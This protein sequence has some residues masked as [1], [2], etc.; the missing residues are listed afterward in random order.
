MLV[1]ANLLIYAIDRDS[2][3]HRRAAAWLRASLRG[4]R[5]IGIPW[6]TLL[7]FFRIVT[8]PR[9]YERPLPQDAAWQLIELWLSCDRVWLPQPTAQHSE[10][11]GQL[12]GQV[13]VRG[14]MI[15][16]AHLAALAYEHGLRIA[17]ADADFKRFSDVQSFN[18][19]AL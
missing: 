5:R 10:V 4:P 18:P 13:F 6:A 14:G 2:P 9:I 7:A 15:H 17:T 1:D 8:S 19:L 16:D 11:M 12:L 3:H